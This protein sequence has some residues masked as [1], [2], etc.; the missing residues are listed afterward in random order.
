MRWYLNASRFQ[1]IH[2]LTHQ[3]MCP[4]HWST[5]RAATSREGYRD[6][7]FLSGLTLPATET[8]ESKALSCA[9]GGPAQRCRKRRPAQTFVWPRGLQFGA[10]SKIGY[11]QFWGFILVFL[12]M[13]RGLGIV[14][15]LMGVSWLS[16]VA[17]VRVSRHLITPSGV[18]L[19]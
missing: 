15:R 16:V 19:K 6:Q 10:Q 4:L 11:Q 5:C 17:E 12:G 7:C 13:L 9:L 3:Y 8:P 2:N 18:D 14:K 1:G